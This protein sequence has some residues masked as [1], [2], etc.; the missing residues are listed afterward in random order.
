MLCSGGHS[1]PSTEAYCIIHTITQELVIYNY[2]CFT[3]GKPEL[4][5]D[6]VNKTNRME[7]GF[8]LEVSF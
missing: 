5:T 3:D 6:K 7:F 8:K 4:Q 1:N 2:S